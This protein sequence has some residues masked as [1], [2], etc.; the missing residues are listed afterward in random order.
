MKLAVDQHFKLGSL[1]VFVLLVSAPLII[2]YYFLNSLQD[3]YTKWPPIIFAVLTISFVFYQAK[4]IIR[5]LN[6]VETDLR[7]SI[8]ELQSSVEDYRHLINGMNEMIWVLDMN[9]HLIDVNDSVPKTLGYDLKELKSFGFNGFTDNLTEEWLCDF[10]SHLPEK[11]LKVMESVFTTKTGKEIP[12]ELFINV[13]MFQGRQSGMIIAR[14]ITIRKELQQK[15][16]EQELLQKELFDSLLVAKVKA[17]ESDRLKMAFLANMSHEIRTPMNGIL[18]FMELLKDSNLEEQ[19][20]QEYIELVNSSGQRLLNTINDIIEISK[21]E[22]GEREV[23]LELVS[24]EKIMNFIY[25]FFKHEAQSLG[26]EFV[27]TEQIKGA[28]SIIITDKFKLDGILTNLVKN[29]IKFT[30]EG[31]VVFGNFLEDGMLHFFVSDTGRGIPGDRLKAIFDRFVQAEEHLARTYEGSGLGLAIAKAYVESL[32]GDMSVE[33]QPYKGS[34]FRFSIPYNTS[35]NN[36]SQAKPE[37]NYLSIKRDG[38]MNGHPFTFLIAE[39]DDISY[40]FLE[41]LMSDLHVNVVRAFTGLEAVKIVRENPHIRMVLMDVKMPD[42]DGLEATRLIR[43]FNKEIPVIAQTAYA[44]PGDKEK[45]REAGCT[46]YISKPINKQKLKD[47][48]ETFVVS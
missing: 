39:D 21:I 5:K 44:L 18:G 11:E 23:K 38:S 32:G 45:T 17:E 7:I 3:I 46:D 34:T 33:S 4:I 16:K 42:L 10:L 24:V 25:D 48:I 8:S 26:L 31:S 20:R 15:Q 40:R 2:H 19:C 37:S 13:V 29:A 12:M 14:D 36:V 47:L 9:G 6:N 30:K 27:L 41:K 1:I 43:K 28:D 35:I 22:S